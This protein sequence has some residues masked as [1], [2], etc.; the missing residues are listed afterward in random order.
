LNIK[1][2]PVARRYGVF[3]HQNGRKAMAGSV[4]ERMGCLIAGETVRYDDRPGNFAEA[5]RLAGRR[6]DRRRAYAI[7]DGVLHEACSFSRPC[8]GCSEDGRR[9]AGCSE[10]GHTG[11]SRQSH[12]IPLQN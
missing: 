11:I 8:S 9:G 10:C 12:W 7:V 3:L 6:L 2:A 4:I 5:E 1:K